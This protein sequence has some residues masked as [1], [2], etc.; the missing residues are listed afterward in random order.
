M[1]GA[2]QNDAPET[3]L[4][5][6]PDTVSWPRLAYGVPGIPPIRPLARLH[7]LG[8]CRPPSL[9]VLD[10]RQS[11]QGV[12]MVLDQPFAAFVVRLV[13]VFDH[14]ALFLG[15]PIYSGELV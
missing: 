9:D 3:T 7:D 15:P 5:T 2:E 4:E 11:Q 14:G 6:V 8:R 1:A 12:A 10:L 13:F